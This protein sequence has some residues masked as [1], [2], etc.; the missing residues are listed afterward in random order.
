MLGRLHSLPRDSLGPCP[1]FSPGERSGCGVS[2]RRRPW[3]PS[4]QRKIR[5]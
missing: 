1:N 4:L 2:L 3:A 5:G